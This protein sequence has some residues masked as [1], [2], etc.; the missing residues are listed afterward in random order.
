[1]GWGVCPDSSK[2]PPCYCR[3]LRVSDHS[4][5][6][7]GFSGVATLSG[8]AFVAVLV[9]LAIPSLGEMAANHREAARHALGQAGSLWSEIGEPG[10]AAVHPGCAVPIEPYFPP[11]AWPAFPIPGP[12]PLP[13]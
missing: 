2:S 8:L 13:F 6:N 3:S 1:M 9:A 12:L 10:Q 5:R 4:D 7:A 11:P